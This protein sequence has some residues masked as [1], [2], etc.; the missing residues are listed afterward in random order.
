MGKQISLIQKIYKN[1]ETFNDFFSY[2]TVVIRIVTQCYRKIRPF[3]MFYNQKLT[4][5]FTKGMW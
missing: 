1:G 3:E 4:L 2:N 5:N